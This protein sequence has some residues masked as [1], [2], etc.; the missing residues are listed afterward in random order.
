VSHRE[1]TEGVFA[2][3]PHLIGLHAAEL[4]A[5]GVER[6]AL[7]TVALFYVI[8]RD[9]VCYTHFRGDYLM[10][11]ALTLYPKLRGNCPG[12]C[13]N[14]APDEVFQLLD[15]VF[16]GN[17]IEFHELASKLR[18][19][20]LPAIEE[21]TNK[22]LLGIPSICPHAFWKQVLFHVPHPD[23]FGQGPAPAIKAEA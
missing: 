23:P 11:E 20:A 13:Q 7:C 4:A 21:E 10:F 8:L 12:G 19:S 18:L 1:R 9:Q 5:W 22:L 17:T 14:L 3:Q 6:I 16:G 15:K 2:I